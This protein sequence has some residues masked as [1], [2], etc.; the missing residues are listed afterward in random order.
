MSH[1][2]THICLI[3]ICIYVSYMYAYMLIHVS[4]YVSYMYAYMSHTYMHI[5]LIYVCICLIHIYAYMYTCCSSSSLVFH[6]TVPG[7]LLHGAYI[8]TYS[9]TVSLGKVWT[10]LVHLLCEVVKLVVK[11]GSRLPHLSHKQLPIHPEMVLMQE[12]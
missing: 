3:H 4:I 9:I 7:I 1:T 5:C 10:H 8:Y 6:Y 11:G 2:C 12:H